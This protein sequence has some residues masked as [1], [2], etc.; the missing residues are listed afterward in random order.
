MVYQPEKSSVRDHRGPSANITARWYSDT[1]TQSVTTPMIALDLSGTTNQSAGHDVALN[2]VINQ[3][4]NQAQDISPAMKSSRPKENRFLLDS[5]TTTGSSWATNSKAATTQENQ[6]FKN[7]EATRTR[8]PLRDPLPDDVPRFLLT[9]AKRRRTASRMKQISALTAAHAH[10][11][12]NNAHNNDQLS[13]VDQHVAP[14]APIL[15]SVFARYTVPLTRVDICV[16]NQNDD[17]PRFLLTQAKRR[18]TAS[19]MKQISALTAAHAHPDLK[20]AHNND[21]LSHVD[22]HVAPSAPILTSA[23]ARYTVPL[24][25]VDI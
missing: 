15:T 20:N 1:T 4:G 16:T 19:R 13:N 11:D 17:V 6:S 14:S 18:R 25:R 9:Q 8:Q 12:L 21:Q 7:H 2:Q 3:S 24:T 10:P 5:A 22:Q 23:F